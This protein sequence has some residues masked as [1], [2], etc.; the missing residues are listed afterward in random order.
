MD[1]RKVVKKIRFCQIE[2]TQNA[3]LPLPAYQSES[4]SGMDISAAVTSPQTLSPGQ[5]AL[6]PTGFAVAI[7]E[8]FELQ[9][10]PRSGLAI[11]HGITII[12]SPGTIDADYRGEVCI[13]V[14]N[15]GTEPFTINRGDRIA[16]MVLAP[17]VKMEI[18]QVEVLDVTKR[19]AGGFGHTGL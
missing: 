13:G 1:K 9:I 19:A 7:P 14:V 6:I 18:E 4:A 2:P 12:N 16:Q 5:I 3:D 8:G 10:R 17:V 15:L 11:R